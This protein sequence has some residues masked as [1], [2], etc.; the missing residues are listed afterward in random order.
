MNAARP[1]SAQVRCRQIAAADLD[2]LADFLTRGFPGRTRAYWVRGL[3]R[4]RT[5]PVP[6]GH[7]RFGYLLEADDA[8]VG[9]LLLIVTDRGAEGVRCNL[10]SW[11]VEP[12]FRSFAP[13]L[14]SAAMKLKD[15]TYLNT[16]PEKHTLAI[17]AARNYRRYSQGQ[18][19]ALP[20]LSGLGRRWA[21]RDFGDGAGF[22]AL[23]EFDLLKRHAEDGCRVL[24]CDAPGGREPFVFI[25]RRIAYSPAPVV[26]LVYCRDTHAFLRCAG[27]VGR[28]LAKRGVGA[29]ILDANAAVPGLFGVYFPG[30]Q[31]RYFRGPAAPR[32]ND[33]AFTEAVV[34]GA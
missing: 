29:V 22:E 30:K 21:V 11:Y 14:T 9:V 2:A 33:L 24:V 5:R 18:F 17:L 27:P 23:A 3:E 20:A 15:V 1:V 31:P 6:D 7:P 28:V 25:P 13:A 34:F 4:L 32:L 16:S 19:V 12:A 10:S 8:I 26:Q